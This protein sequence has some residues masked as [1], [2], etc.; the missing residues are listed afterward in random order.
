MSAWAIWS[1]APLCIQQSEEAEQVFVCSFTPAM[2]QMRLSGDG[3]RC[4]LKLVYADLPGTVAEELEVRGSLIFGSSA[5][6]LP[7]DGAGADLG[8]SRCRAKDCC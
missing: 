4:A 7:N 8:A 5:Y 3:Q 1:I 2:L 6:C